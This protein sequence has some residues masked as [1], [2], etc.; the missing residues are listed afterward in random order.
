MDYKTDYVQI[1]NEHELIKKY[2]L[3]LDIYRRALEEALGKN[4]EEVYI[5]SL[6]LNKEIKI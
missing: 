6:C 4:I 2:K 3:Q 1:G 5:Y